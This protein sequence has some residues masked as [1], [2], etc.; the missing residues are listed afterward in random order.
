MVKNKLKEYI[1]NQLDNL[2]IEDI[3]VIDTSKTSSIADWV[4]IGSGRSGK[5]I[6]SS[7][8]ILKF[9]MKND[10]VYDGGIISGVANDGWII[11]DL[12]DIIVHLFVPAVRDIYKLEQLLNPKFS[13]K[14]ENIQSNSKQ[15]GILVDPPQNV[16]NKK[17]IK[18]AETKKIDKVLAKNCN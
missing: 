3:I 14:S 15:T 5:H 18:T 8:D 9:N 10:G 2:K 16:E 17:S 12:G 11:F 7:M 13:N 6:E 1:V 4:I